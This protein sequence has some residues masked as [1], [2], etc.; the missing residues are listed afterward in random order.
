M[1]TGLVPPSA[2]RIEVL[3]LAPDSVEAKRQVGAMPED[4]AL[5]DMLTG[6]QYLRFVGRM[7]GSRMPKLIAGRRNSS[8][9]W[10]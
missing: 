2:G 5:L 9:S 7:H 4:M 10:I 3:G 6:P 8:T 1:V